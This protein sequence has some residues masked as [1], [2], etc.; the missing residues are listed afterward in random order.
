[1]NLKLDALCDD[2]EAALERGERPAISDWAKSE[3]AIPEL[4][5]LELH[6][7]L[8]AGEVV[9]AADYFAM[10]PQLL[11]NREVAV[12]LVG[13]EYRAAVSRDSSLTERHFRERYPDLANGQEWSNGPWVSDTA[14][15]AGTGTLIQ[16]V[17]PKAPSVPTVKVDMPDFLANILQSP[18]AQHPDD[19]GRL[20]EYRVIEVLD[21]GGMGVVL[22]GANIHSGHPAAIKLMLPEAAAQGRE[23][24]LRE[25]R[26]AHKID[27]QR[28]VPIYH[29][30]EVNGAPYIVMKLLEGQS[31]AKRLKEG[32]PLSM[33]EIIRIGREIAEGLKAAH[34]LDLV[35]RDLKPDNIWME[36]TK[37]GEHVR[38]LDFGLARPIGNAA[39]DGVRN[40]TIGNVVA[41]TPAYMSPEQAESHELDARTDLWSLGVVLYRLV[42]NQLPFGDSSVT[43]VLRAIVDNTPKPLHEANSIVPMRLSN[44]VMKLLE[45]QP[46][47]RHSSAE[48]VIAEFKQIEAASLVPDGTTITYVS[49]DAKPRKSRRWWPMGITA[50]VITLVI[51]FITLMPSRE[52][53]TT[54]SM[55]PMTPIAP[56]TPPPVE[57]LAVKFI[58]VKHYENWFIRQVRTRP[59][60]S[61]KCVARRIP[62]RGSRRLGVG[63]S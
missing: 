20:G 54:V 24:F 50:A 46:K 17:P 58:A 13:V 3:A 56:V 43:K 25:A 33:D 61:R 55:K 51:G 40:V 7:R 49:P 42:A 27:D 52:P 9:T 2:F 29:V 11:A 23:R 18:F 15:V 26:A 63:A 34:T 28:V 45:K 16:Q 31:L 35:H 14:V 4:A 59:G 38:I 21:R 62:G 48:A 60:G 5:A 47:N 12:R 10:Y 1:M 41:G 37:D 36:T 22:K 6:H 39:V 19:I 53:S 32:P 30:G 57:P 44:L 8:I